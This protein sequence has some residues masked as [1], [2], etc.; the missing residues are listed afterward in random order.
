VGPPCGVSPRP[1]TAPARRHHAQPRLP[2]LATEL[3]QDGGFPANA[4][5]AGFLGGHEF[6][7]GRQAV[8]VVAEEGSR[9]ERRHFRFEGSARYDVVAHPPIFHAAFSRSA[10][11]APLAGAEDRKGRRAPARLESGRPGP[12]PVGEHTSAFGVDFALLFGQCVQ[13]V[14]QLLFSG[15]FHAASSARLISNVRSI[16]RRSAAAAEGFASAYV[17]E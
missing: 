12:G 11:S 1:R 15:R 3:R 13:L 4:R 5:D 9:R 16:C 8:P 7:Q 2:C 6:T 14:S 17:F 10:S